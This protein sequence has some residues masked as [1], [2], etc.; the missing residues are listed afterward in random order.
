[1]NPKVGV[2]MV[3]AL[4]LV[5]SWAFTN[6]EH[7][8]DWVRDNQLSSD[9]SP[10]ALLPIQ[11]EERWL[12]LVADFPSQRAS[13]AWGVNQ[14]QNMLDDIARSYIEQLTNGQTNLTIVVHQEVATA[15]EDVGRYGS[16]FEGNRDTD[17]AGDFLPLDLAEEVVLDM[18]SSVNWSQFDLNDD[19]E[20]D[21][22][23]ILHTTK[24]Q[25]ENP[26]QSEK[27][28]SHFTHFETPLDVGDGLSVG[29]YTMA[30]LRTGS[31]GMGT[32]LHEMLHQMGALDLYPVH[33]SS[34]DTDWHGVGDWDIMA[35]GNWNGGGA[36]PALPTSP[37]MELIGL[38]RVIEMDLEWPEASIAPCIGPTVEMQGMSEGGMALKIPLNDHEHVWIERH[39]D[40]GFSGHLPG[41]G[42]LV[43]IQDR[44]VGDEE[45]NELNRDSEQPWLAVVEADGE[46]DMRRGLNDGEGED[47]FQNGSSF[48][49]SG[50]QI[51]NHDGF[52]VPWTATV[53]GTTNMSIA[54]TSE[55]CTP[56]FSANGPDFG[57]V[58]LPNQPYNITVE[59]SQPCNLSQNLTLS[60]GRDID[61]SPTQ[62]SV[63]STE[64][65]LAFAWNGTANS[66]SILEGVIECGLGK[67]DLSTS[68]LTLAR[69][70]TPTTVSG[71]MAV[72]DASQV[73]IP[74]A[75][76]GEGE[77]SF[78]LDLDGPMSRVGTVDSRFV[79]NG[80]DDLIIDINP[81]G[82]LLDGMI[83][84]GDLTFIDSN[85]HRWTYE[86]NFV[87][88]ESEPSAFEE[89]RTPARIVGAFC[90]VAALYVFL[91]VLEHKKKAKGNISQTSEEP[92]NIEEANSQPPEVDPW[93]RPVDSFE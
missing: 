17:S 9:E 15:S 21:R 42:I 32:V 74:I 77:Q 54:F 19:D 8:D 72:D 31:S 56:G 66:E 87:A 91:G 27:I 64:V 53:Q 45:R 83:V 13:E 79:L 23:L 55:S 65:Q 16:D 58:L 25:E 51:R 22:L 75:S 34:L 2:P 30:S 14:A 36:W 60:D 41:A 20:V 40:V 80:E 38:N 88:Q 7:I 69:I 73:V 11:E 78:T 43:M 48:G 57:A 86:L 3:I 90:L 4:L 52:L 12:V 68:L 18:A 5:S 44:S 6:G 24:G 93:G 49:A 47:L 46:V 76:I 85:G 28:W 35:S 82:L 67:L 63:G 10:E 84:R 33:D 29:H 62:L 92:I 61:A 70:P 89:L 50:I 59:T 71:T 81:N 39:T 37:T 1:M 26:A